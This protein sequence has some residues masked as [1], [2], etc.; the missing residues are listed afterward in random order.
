MRQFIAASVAILI[1]GLGLALAQNTAKKRAAPDEDV[2]LITSIRGPDLYAAYCAVCHG[3]DAK[4]GGPMAAALKKAPPDL[5]KL[6][7]H[8]GG[9][10]P[11]EKV[12]D[13]ISGEATQGSH[14]TREMP[15]WGPIFSQVTRDQDLG[16]VRIDN[17]ARYLE[18]LQ[19]M[20][21]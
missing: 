20:E 17:L 8:N 18:T 14:G 11:R 16:H 7:L 19:E 13:I 4:G 2:R 10:F 15:V 3:A 12:R 21:P 1:A 9:M 6:A 5:T